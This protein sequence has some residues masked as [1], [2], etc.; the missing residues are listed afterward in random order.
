MMEDKDI[1]T[2]LNISRSRVNQLLD[3]SLTKIINHLLKDK[4]VISYYDGDLVKFSLAITQELNIT[5]IKFYKLSDKSLI[6][7]YWSY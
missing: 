3:Q 5:H 1:A 4:D 2:R 6:S 7:K